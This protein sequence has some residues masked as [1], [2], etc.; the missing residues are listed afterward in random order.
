MDA[1]YALN[2]PLV[3]VRNGAGS[4]LIEVFLGPWDV[5]YRYPESM[6]SLSLMPYGVKRIVQPYCIQNY[7]HTSAMPLLSLDVG[8]MKLNVST[9]DLHASSFN[10]ILRRVAFFKAISM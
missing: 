7:S 2:R 5:S 3:R 8:F 1:E 6:N 4:G 9:L 10:R